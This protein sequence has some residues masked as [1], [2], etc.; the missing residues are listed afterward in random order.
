MR[1]RV[2]MGSAGPVY[3]EIAQ[4]RACQDF[5]SLA[6]Q[7]NGQLD[8]HDHCKAC[9]EP[10]EKPCKGCDVLTSVYCFEDDSCLCP[11]CV[12]DNERDAAAEE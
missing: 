7:P 11:Q 10:E 4:C 12:E 6:E 3:I 1:M 9:A 2:N 8:V 5:V